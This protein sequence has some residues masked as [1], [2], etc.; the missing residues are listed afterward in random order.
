MEGKVF[1]VSTGTK[2]LPAKILYRKNGFQ[3][4]AEIQV[5]DMIFVTQFERQ[6]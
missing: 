1:R 3:E 4:M 2:N 5:A 6:R